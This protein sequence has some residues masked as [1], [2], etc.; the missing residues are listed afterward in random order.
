MRP[1]HT[2]TEKNAPNVILGSPT[3]R[4]KNMPGFV[5][6]FVIADNIFHLNVHYVCYT[7]LVQHSE[8]QGM[9][10]TNFHYYYY[11]FKSRHPLTD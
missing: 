5:V 1:L 11:R 6:V 2:R 9:R 7:M 8:L 4:T 10:F 3:A